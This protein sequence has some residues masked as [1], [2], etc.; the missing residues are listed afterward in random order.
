MTR[1]K[2]SDYIAKRLREHY[3]VNDIFMVSGGGA[4][5]LNDSFGRYINYIAN[6]HEQA[7]SIAA[8][9]YARV[10]QKLAVVNVT[11]GPGGLN[12]LNGLF[13]QWTDSVPV[14]YISGQV[15]TSTC[16]ASCPELNLRQLGDQEVDI[17]SVVKPLTKFAK[18]ITKPEDIK[19]YLDKAIY[20]ATNGRFGP[21][22]IDV[23]INVQAAFIEEE[24]LK[25]FIPE[26]DISLDKNFDLTKFYNASKPLIVAGHGIRLSGQIENFKAL[27][28]K[29]NIPVVTTFNSM[30]VF[31]SDD[32][33]FVGRIGTVGQRAGNYALQNADVVLCLGTRNNIRQV[34]YNWENFAKNAYKIVVDIDN[35]ELDKP[36]VIPDLKINMD[37]KDFIPKLN[38]KN[39][40]DDGWLNFCKNVQYKYSFENIEAYK[41]EEEINVYDFVHELTCNMAENSILVAANGSACVCLHQVG[42]V[43]ANQR[44]I[45]NSG[46]A[47]MG[48]DLPAA[49]GACVYSKK[50]VICLA[51][52]GS[53]MMNIQEL[54]T[55]VKNNLPIKIFVIN[56]CGYSSIR[57]TQRNFFNGRMTA[58]GEDSGVSVPD[59]CAVA[60]AFNLK[61]IKLDR[62]E[63]MKDVIEY[64]LSCNEPILCEIVTQQEYIFQPKL[65]SRINPDGT[66]TSPALDDMYPFVKK[67]IY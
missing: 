61:S 37:L 65:S 14:L 60:N 25:E 24:S 23:P 45:F 38:L 41:S 17:V 49:V 31:E 46:N 28:K 29:T 18:M 16:L 43:K 9:G 44:V 11:T 10:A 42:I 3:D 33:N 13:G 20:E 35:A 58:S 53:I 1:I 57:Q 7:C 48:Y 39:C 30:D 15:K 36:L 26:V 51:G 21:V 4:M 62:C 67:E 5:H 22:W 55:I 64:V 63:D 2:V 52:D 8:E 54:Q 47:S 27:I 40:R 12:C 59:F 56:N 32:K 34:S 50:P 6:H 19:Y 66:M